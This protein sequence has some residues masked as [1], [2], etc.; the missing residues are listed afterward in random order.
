MNAKRRPPK[1][2]P[3]TKGQIAAAK[4]KRVG[5]FLDEEVTDPANPRAK[6][7]QLAYLRYVVEPALSLEDLNRVPPFDALKLS[8]LR[9]WCVEDG[10]TAG[11][12]EHYQQV[13]ASIV[14]HMADQQV[15]AH[16][17]NLAHIRT[18]KDQL[19][20]RLRAET[21]A[22]SAGDKLVTA[23]CKLLATESELMGATVG[24]LAPPPTTTEVKDAAPHNQ[25][26]ESEARVVAVALMRHRREE[27]ERAQGQ[28]PPQEPAQ[29]AQPEAVNEPDAAA[30]HAGGLPDAG[31]GA[32]P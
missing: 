16:L 10:W 24:V 6:L 12:Q 23:F 26:S 15:R 7:R 31:D 29:A 3:V 4:K 27:L 18:I 13:R 25:L 1:K 22:D 21:F 9:F 28:N 20:T 32:V 14:K 2:V 8:T 11:R 17:D 19:M 30:E 5:E